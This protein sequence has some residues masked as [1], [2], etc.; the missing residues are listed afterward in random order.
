MKLSTLLRTKKSWCQHWVAK[1]SDGQSVE[2]HNRNA[3]S[4]C[5]LGGLRRC[6]LKL[7]DN[8][9]FC[10]MRARVEK[11]LP[12]NRSMTGFNDDPSTK[13]ADIRRL[14]KKAKV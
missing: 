7:D 12:L 5:L 14:I 3:V 1:D 10:R 6:Y 9:L 2:I 11:F 8:T 4:F 13:F